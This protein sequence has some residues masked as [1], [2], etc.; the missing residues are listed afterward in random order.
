MALISFKNFSFRYG[1]LKQPTLKNINLDINAGE[2]LLIAGPSGS[3]KSTL[4][5]C[6][7]GLIPF[8]YKGEITGSLTIKNFKPYEKSIYEISEVVGTI[9]Q[10]QDGQFVGLS[11]GEDVAFSFENN[12]IPQEEMF[13]KVKKSL[14]EVEMLD[15]INESPHNLSGGQKQKVSMAGILSSDAEVLL[16]DEPLANLDPVS[17]FKAMETIDKIHEATGKTIIIVEHRIEDVLAHNF[18]RVVVVNNGEIAADGTPDEILASDS[19]KEYGL[20]EPLYVEV[21]KNANINIKSEDKLS[22]IENAY[23]FKDTILNLYKENKPSKKDI[24]K[25]SLLSI[26]NIS[27]KY[28]DDMPYTI[29]DVSFDINKGEILAILGNNGAGKST[30][31]KVISGICKQQKGTIMYNGKKID[32]W[33]V[34]KRGKFIGYVMQNPNHMITKNMIF[35]EVAFGLVNYGFKSEEIE[36]RVIDA[37]TICGLN[38]YKKWPVSSLSYGQKKRLT[39]ASILAMKPEIIILDE[40]TA[41]QDYRNYK[42]FMGFLENVKNTGVSIIMITHDMH[43]ALEYADRAVVLSDGQVI[44]DNSVYEVLSNEDVIKRANLKETSISELGHLY[45]IYDESDFLSFFTG[46]LKEGEKIE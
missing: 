5:H 43:L 6:I 23:K 12:K 24:H 21:L 28:F 46:R 45:G 1:N 11:V 22:K 29:K 14:K 31:F 40:P 30:L 32:K 36:K 41:G 8:T 16:F 35:D 34:R 44:D 19:L 4:A 15:Y 20:R 33:S 25:T 17:G 7:N 13:S 10:D 42:E 38:K 39:I 18:D 2:K 37:L 9:L 27:Y 3:G 26:K